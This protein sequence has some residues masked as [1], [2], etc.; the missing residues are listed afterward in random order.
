MSIFF[1]DLAVFFF[2][3]KMF[4]E[5]LGATKKYPTRPQ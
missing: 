2:T 1:S 3:Q 4:I 5:T